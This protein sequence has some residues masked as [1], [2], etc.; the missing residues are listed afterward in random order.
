MAKK[1]TPRSTKTAR[2]GAPGFP[3]TLKGHTG[4][5][6]SASFSPDNT[7]VVTASADKTLKLW[8]T[9]SGALLATYQTKGV[10][11]AS[12]SP[13]G[14]LIVAA[15]GDK[16]LQLWPAFGDD[17]QKP[18]S[19]ITKTP[20][21]DAQFSANGALII[22]VGDS[23]ARI[24]GVDGDSQWKLLVT[25]EDPKDDIKDARLSPDGTRASTC[26][27]SDVSKLWAIDDGRVL[28]TFSNQTELLTTV[29]TPE[30]VAYVISRSLEGT[31]KIWDIDGALISI[32]EGHTELVNSAKLSP[33][34]SRIVTACDDLTAKVWEV[35]S[36]TLLASLEGH[37][38]YL[39]SAELSPD[40]SRIVTASFDNTA[41]LWKAP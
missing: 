16:G 3:I 13:D 1:T 23:V 14:K 20:S 33:D 22:A 34:G 17:A 26:G 4:E 11:R 6:L 30:N 21:N 27:F 28:S 40:G 29:F 18:L 8:E 12:F 24:W 35:K 41:M 15:H 19:L 39:N 25:L 37:T 38:K 5:V 31:V 36:G 32:L 7:R 10:R 2:K 9:S